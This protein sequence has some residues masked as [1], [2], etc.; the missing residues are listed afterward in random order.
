MSVL[1]QRNVIAYNRGISFCKLS[2]IR[3][4]SAGTVVQKESVDD[5]PVYEYGLS[6]AGDRKLYV[7][8]L[9]EHGGLGVHHLLKKNR[10]PPKYYQRPSSHNLAHICNLKK[11]SAS[12]AQ[13]VGTFYSG[14]HKFSYIDF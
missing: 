11:I 9:V 5:L 1:L 14:P 10:F 6:G 8:G 4:H 13:I 3:K 2:F 7:W 12:F